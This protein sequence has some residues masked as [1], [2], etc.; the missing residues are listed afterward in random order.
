MEVCTLSR[1]AMS[2]LSAQPLSALLL[3]GIRFLHPPVPALP[4]VCLAIH[5]PHWEEYGVPTFRIHT[6]ERRRSRLSAG[7]LSIC[8]RRGKEAPGLATYLLVQACQPL[9]LV[10]VHDVYQRFT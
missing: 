8:A 2:P 9:W 3:S 7:G 10:R 4:L 1:E 5:L 6:H